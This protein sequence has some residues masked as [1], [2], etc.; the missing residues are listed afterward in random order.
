[1]I[2]PT[3]KAGIRLCMSMALR[4]VSVAELS[5]KI[6]VAR[7]VLYRFRKGMRTPREDRRIMIANYL[8]VDYDWLWN[9]KGV[10]HEIQLLE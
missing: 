1:M 6:G 5:E 8:D 4:S 10:D 2:K 7:T 9:E 3:T